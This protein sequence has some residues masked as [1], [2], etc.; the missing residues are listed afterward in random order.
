MRISR[1]A[2]FAA[3]LGSALGLAAGSAGAVVVKTDLPAPVTNA[4]ALADPTSTSGSV[5]IDFTGNNFD[6]V[7][8]SALSPFAGTAFED[9]AVYH[10]VS[11][12]AEAR[13]AFDRPQTQFSL[14][15]GSPDSYNRLSFL[16]DG[17]EVF[18]LVGDDVVSPGQL[19]SGAVYVLIRDLSFDEVRFSSSGD[20]FEFSNLFSLAQIPV[21]AS[22]PLLFGALAG[23]GI[24]TRRRGGRGKGQA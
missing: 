4:D 21:P 11:A 3:V 1:G 8:P 17:V 20:A 12:G 23:L 14:L 19:G 16:L 24:L 5:R 10:A 13:Y 9:V 7:T 15:F 2:A 18:D 22:L 6:G